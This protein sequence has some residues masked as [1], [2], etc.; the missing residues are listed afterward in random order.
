M[1]TL[2]T[3]ASSGIGAALATHFAT[4]DSHL[5]LVARRV[6]R[7]Q[8]V[9]A[10]CQAKGAT[11]TLYSVDL[12][13][14]EATAQL[15]QTLTQHT[16][17]RIILNAGI[18]TGHHALLTPIEQAVQLYNTNLLGVHALLVPL[19]PM[20]QA[21]KSG[22]IVFISSLAS[23][24]TMP[25]SLIYASSKRALNAYAQGLEN[26]LLHDGIDVSMI[27]PGFIQSE[28]TAK[29]HFKMPFLLSLEAGSARIAHAIERRRR[30]YAFPFRFVAII[31]ALRMLPFFLRGR[32]VRF[33]NFNKA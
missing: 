19:I 15:G 24:Y 20:L 10:L 21:Q 22:H 17:D 23:L 4:P 9:A 12:S 32:L 26:M 6:E 8:E 29:N 2:I 25:S 31:F 28:L 5:I 33:A 11:V 13:D 3:G 1:T 14:L 7:L 18:S 27:L 16:I 30:F